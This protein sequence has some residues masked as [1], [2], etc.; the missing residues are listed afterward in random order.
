MV[1]VGANIEEL[2]RLAKSFNQ[3]ADS[4]GQIAGSL[5]A[6]VSASP[7][8]G[9]DANNFRSGWSNQY[10]RQLI[11]VA[12][13]LRDGSSSLLANAAEQEKASADDGG[14]HYVSGGGIFEAGT[15]GVETQKSDEDDKWLNDK[16]ASMSFAEKKSF[17]EN[18]SIYLADKYGLDDPP[19]VRFKR[20]RKKRLGYYDSDRNR[21]TLNRRSDS[22]EKNPLAAM[23]TVAH[24]MR[25]A[26]QRQ[27]V[28]D[29]D[30][31][32]FAKSDAAKEINK[33]H[34]DSGW[35]DTPILT[36][37]P[38]SY[39]DVSESTARTWKTNQ[40][41]YI[42]GLKK[43]NFKFYEQQ[44]IE[45]DAR[46]SAAQEVSVVTREFFEFIENYDEIKNPDASRKK[47]KPGG[48]GG[49]GGS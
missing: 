41:N 47:I 46:E 6:Q 48:G 8:Q 32:D 42:S 23:D 43:E 14:V 1:V 45:R 7:W 39:P 15:N 5:G 40:D 37:K 28:R 31:A 30:R 16:W 12:T 34:I 20:L 36:E 38:W 10:H 2:R 49:G 4:L 21:I 27:V 18:Y 33:K 11:Q 26:Y 13:G 35:S 9:Y 19:T 44:P 22:F 3:A 25:H 24:E 17:L 29:L